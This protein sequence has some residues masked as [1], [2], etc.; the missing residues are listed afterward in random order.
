MLDTLAG[1]GMTPPV[2]V[3]DAGYGSNADFRAGLAERGIAYVLAVRSDVTAH[4]FDAQPAA[5]ARL[6]RQ[7]PLAPAPLPA[8]PRLG[9]SP[10]RRPSGRRH[11]PR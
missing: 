1:W 10:G 8:P 5:P 2:V 3:A 4:P 6:G 11:S 7:R 9:G